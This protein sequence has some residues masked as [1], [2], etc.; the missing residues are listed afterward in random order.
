MY[1][2]RQDAWHQIG[3]N[4]KLIHWVAWR[5]AALDVVGLVVKYEHGVLRWL[6]A[7]C[8]NHRGE[9]QRIETSGE[10]EGGKLRHTTLDEYLDEEAAISRSDPVASCSAVLLRNGG[11]V[12]VRSC[13]EAK[14]L[15]A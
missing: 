15:A 3:L 2:G 8:G 11:S 6:L 14:R 7:S 4:H 10:R 5:C 9:L 12:A 13:L 1:K